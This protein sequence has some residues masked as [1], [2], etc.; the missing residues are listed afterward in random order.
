M[1]KSMKIL[2]GSI[3]NT[4]RSWK[5]KDLR[6]GKICEKNQGAALSKMPAILSEF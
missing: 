2:I 5:L 6:N 4:E 1:I 3:T